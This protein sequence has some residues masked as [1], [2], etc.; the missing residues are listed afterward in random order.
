MIKS[1][2][3]RARNAIPSDEPLSG[4]FLAASTLLLLLIVATRL[5]PVVA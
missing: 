1:A 5:L 3:P 4:G 2:R